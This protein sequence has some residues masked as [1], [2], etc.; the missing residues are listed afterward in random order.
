MVHPTNQRDFNWN[1]GLEFLYH[2]IGFEYSVLIWGRALNSG[3]TILSLCMD[4]ISTASAF[5]LPPK[6][7]NVFGY[8]ADGF[9]LQS[10]A[11]YFQNFFRAK[12]LK[13]NLITMSKIRFKKLREDNHNEKHAWWSLDKNI[14]VNHQE[15]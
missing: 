6:H 10:N 9:F 5:L 8:E 12:C 11:F 14:C 15:V 4:K 13:L 3:E 2:I 1:S 7:F